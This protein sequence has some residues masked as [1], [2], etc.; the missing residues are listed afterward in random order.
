MGLDPPDRPLARRERRAAARR[1]TL[2]EAPAKPALPDW[3]TKIHTWTPP[4]DLEVR[5]VKVAYLVDGLLQLGKAGV[6]VAGGGTG[7]TTLLIQLLICIATGRKFLGRIVR[8]G[9]GVLFSSDDSQADLDAALALVVQAQ[10]PPLSPAEL[11]LVKVKARIHSLQDDK[12][13]KTFSVTENGSPRPTDL[14]YYVNHAL[15]GIDDLVFVG[16]D[17]VRQFSGGNSNDET[18][19]GIA[20]A[21]ATAIANETGATVA[22]SHHT[23]KANYRDGVEDMYVGSGSAAIADNSRFVLLLQ[24]TAWPDVNAKVRRSGQESGDPLVLHSTRGSL[25]VRPPPPTFLFRDGYRFGLISGETLTKD[26]AQDN[27]DREIIRAVA[28]GRQSGTAIRAAVGC[29]K[30]KALVLVA[31]LE[32]RGHIR[33][34][35]TAARPHYVVSESGRRFLE[36]AE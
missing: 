33:N 8:Y 22:F 32:R 21:G 17:T 10:V 16:I 36:A 12:G 9:T 19:M 14:P 4:T 20:I 1:G 7:K 34:T 11:A 6:L 13:I 26:Q 2:A 28:D 25:L 31:N 18:V 24:K 23:G 29:A 15:S 27:L 3:V 30:D 35:R 5:Q